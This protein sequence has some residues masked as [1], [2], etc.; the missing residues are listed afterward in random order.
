M[1]IP[2]LSLQRITALHGDE[3]QTAVDNVVKSGW[4]LH[5]EATTRLRQSMRVISE[6]VIVSAA[7]MVWML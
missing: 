7:V 5:G 2:Y 3:I 1:D 6:R 4:Y